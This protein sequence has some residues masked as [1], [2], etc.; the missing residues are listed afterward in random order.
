[1]HAED[2]IGNHHT[3]AGIAGF[4]EAPLQIRHVC[5]GITK[6]LRLAKPDPIDDGGVIQLIGNHRI[7][8]PQQCLEQ[9][10]IGIEAGGIEDGVFGRK[11]GGNPLFQLFV[12]SLYHQ[13]E[14]YIILLNIHYYLSHLL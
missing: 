14:K 6:S 7:F 4:G 8:G 1:M 12:Y 2:A 13:V 9:P 3:G 10:T 5:M 11:K